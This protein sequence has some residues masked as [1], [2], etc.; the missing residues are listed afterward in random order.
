MGVSKVKISRTISSIVERSY[1][2][3]SRIDKKTR[4][5]ISEVLLPTDDDEDKQEITLDLTKGELYYIKLDVLGP[6]GGTGLLEVTGESGPLI[7]PRKCTIGTTG[8]AHCS[9]EF[10]A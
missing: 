4:K 3:L 8:I 9:D 5:T 7:K 6:K 10:E 2:I 1:L